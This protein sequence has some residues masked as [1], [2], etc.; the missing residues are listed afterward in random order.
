MPFAAH[1]I[2]ADDGL[3]I[4]AAALRPEGGAIVRDRLAGSG[5]EAASLG[6]RIAE[7]LLGRG[8]AELAAEG[9]A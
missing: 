5:E 7:L 4:E 2:A 3:T 6:E 8:A 1:A 9:V